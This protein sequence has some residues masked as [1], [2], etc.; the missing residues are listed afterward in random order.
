M[1]STVDSQTSWGEFFFLRRKGNQKG[2]T[3]VLGIYK[4]EREVKWRDTLVYKNR[5][6][7]HNMTLYKLEESSI[8]RTQNDF[9][10]VE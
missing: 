7:E 5:G 6:V 4:G 3:R 8:G 2:Q 9:F 1:S 10:F